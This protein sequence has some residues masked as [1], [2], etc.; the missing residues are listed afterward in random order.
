MVIEEETQEE[1]RWRWRGEELQGMRGDYPRWG[2][3]VQALR[4]RVP[5][6]APRAG[7]NGGP[8]PDDQGP[9]HA[10]SH[11]QQHVPKGTTGQGQSNFTVLGVAQPMQ[12]QSRSLGVY[13]LH[14]LEARLGLPQ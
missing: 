8:A 7:R 13:P 4:L 10:V 9:G 6:Q 11:D 12:E 5:A 2:D 3:E 14:G 1:I